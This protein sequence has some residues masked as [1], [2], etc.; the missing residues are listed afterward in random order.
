MWGQILKSNHLALGALLPRTGSYQL[1][2]K[3]CPIQSR[4]AVQIRYW[5][6]W[7]SPAPKLHTKARID[8]ATVNAAIA[9]RLYVQRRAVRSVTTARSI[10]LL[11]LWNIARALQIC[12]QVVNRNVLVRVNLFRRGVDAGRSREDLAAKKAVNARGENPPVINHNSNCYGCEKRDP[13]DDVWMKDATTP[14]TP[15]ARLRLAIFD[16]ARYGA[17]PLSARYRRD[18]IFRWMTNRHKNAVIS[19]E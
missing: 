13:Y 4:S 9:A 2:L 10:S 7:L 15:D 18:A 16:Y 11:R 5:S 14:A 17:R 6:D 8:D 12:C 1:R 19:D 3:L